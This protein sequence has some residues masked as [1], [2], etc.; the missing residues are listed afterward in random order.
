MYITSA[1]LQEFEQRYGSPVE[2]SAQFMMQPGEFE[3]LRK[4]RKNER[5]HDVTFFI[6][7]EN[8]WIVNSKHWYPPGLY[9]IPSG[10]IK[11]GESIEDGIRREVYE[12]TGCEIDLLRYFMRIEVRFVCA[13][14]HEDWVSYLILADWLSGQLEPVDVREIKEVVLASRRDFDKFT[15]IMLSLDVGGLH[16]RE[17]LQRNAFEQL[18]RLGY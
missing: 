18:D 1:M 3:F 15:E 17:F 7:K 5:S 12:E 4:S 16:Y 11:L 6:R 10:G 13:S 8:L 2:F 14:E 9:R